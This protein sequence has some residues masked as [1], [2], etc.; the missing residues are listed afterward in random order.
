VAGQ[1][2]ITQLY[3]R[4]LLLDQN[5]TPLASGYRAE[6]GIQI[7]GGNEQVRYFLSASGNH[8]DGTL[9]MPQMEQAFLRQERAVSTL[10]GEQLD[11]NELQKLSLRSNLSAMLSNNVDVTL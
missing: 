2:T 6:R 1:C 5:T 10:P 9:R 11:P 8:E 7:N 4:N 3:S